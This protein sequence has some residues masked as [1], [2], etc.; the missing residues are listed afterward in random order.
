MKITPL[1]N[2]V[3]LKKFK[4]E[5][6]KKGIIIVDEKQEDLH[7]G[8]LIDSGSGSFIECDK[9]RSGIH[10]RYMPYTAQIIKDGDDEYLLIEDKNILAIIEDI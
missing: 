6:K 1:R 7:L 4:P 2:Q 9:I 10:V 5:P 3:L 8:I